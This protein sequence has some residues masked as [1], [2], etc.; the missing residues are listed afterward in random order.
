MTE[1][2]LCRSTVFLLVILAQCYVPVFGAPE[3]EWVTGWGTEHED[4]VFEGV[5]VEGGGFCVVGK[6]G[7]PDSST[8][9]G[10]VMKVDANGEQEWLTVLGKQG[11]HDEARCIIEV[12]DGFIVGGTTGISERKSKACL[13]K[14]SPSG[15]IKWKKI[16]NHKKNGAIR[17]LDTLDAESF[18]ATGYIASDEISV[19]F[20]SDESTGILLVS[21]QSGDIAWQKEIPFSQGAKVSCRKESSTITVCGTVWQE[22]FEHEHQ[23]AFLV[24]FSRDGEKLQQHLYGN[25]D[26]EQCFDFEALPDGFVLAGHK[27]SHESENWDVWIMRT[28]TEGNLLWEQT[29]DQLSNGTSKNLFDECYGVKQTSDGGFVLACGSGIEPDHVSDEDSP[30]NLWAACLLKTDSLGEPCW[31]Y[32]F[33]QP[34]S[35]HNACEWVI[36]HGDG[37]YLMLLDSDHLGEAEPSNVGLVYVSDN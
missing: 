31:T 29:Y 35:G 20:I 1:L 36:P 21:N 17:G 10:F 2:Y 19:P 11:F 14:I 27:A 26:M 30:D 16:L 23:D 37:K 3:V 6:C 25:A 5:H 9:N 28:D 33:H 4:H 34:E 32:V 12:H 13:W 24:Q 15:A 7:D 8:A 18:V 22:S